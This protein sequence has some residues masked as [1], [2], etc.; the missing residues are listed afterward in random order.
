MR[1]FDTLYRT[2]RVLLWGCLLF[3][4]MVRAGGQNTTVI[5]ADFSKSLI[6]PDLLRDSARIFSVEQMLQ[7]PY[8]SQFRSAGT[9]HLSFGADLSR[10]WMRFS[11]QNNLA[12]P[13]TLILWLNRKNFDEFRLWQ[14]KA[15]G[16]IQAFKEVGANFYDD[17]RFSLT[18][19]YYIAVT[20]QPGEN[21]FWANASN[22]VG[23]M[24]LGLSLHTPDAFALMNRESVL[25]FGIF[26]GVMLISIVFAGQLFFMH[27]DTMYLLYIG[28]VLTILFREAYNHSAIFNIAPV[29]QRHCISFLMVAAYG[30]FYRYFVRLWELNKWVDRITKWYLSIIFCLVAVF[31]GMVTWGSPTMVRYVFLAVMISILLITGVSI[32]VVVQNFRTN[33]RARIVTIAFTPLAFA[34]ILNLLRNIN[35]VPNYPFIQSAVM[36]G[37]IVEVVIFTIAFTRWHR[38]IAND[39]DLLQLKLSVEQQERLLAVQSAEQRVKDSIARDLHDDVAASLS[40]IRIL[41][42][43]AQEQ[44]ASKAPEAAPLLDQISRSAH[45]TLESIS[46]LIWAVKPHPDYLNDM[47]DR[48]REYAVRVLEAK[49]VDYQMNIPR[50]LPVVDLNV[51]SRRNAYLIFKE[52][53]NNALKHSGC[54]RMDFDFQADGS[55][56]TL[57]IVDN[58]KGFDLNARRHSGIG[59]SS[60]EKRAREINGGLEVLSAPGQGTHIT[61]TLP[62]QKN[63]A[64]EHAALVGHSEN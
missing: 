30:L 48:M 64:R 23:S 13:K 60:M 8:A 26:L 20:L 58:G 12:T 45:T 16:E 11:V 56:M 33:I 61:F 5:D 59:L 63:V 7:E 42:K 40:G 38:S 19:G 9:P 18:N 46:D 43:V 32:V 6:T 2:G 1:N 27:R 28:Y 52:A 14:Q 4:P 21:R 10:W 53:V 29:M 54:T 57:H 49:D 51:E 34:F 17:A 44:F 35:V 62:L 25:L 55:K 50:N 41:S 3:L 39:R 47:A 15:S 37:F 31:G 36:W 22:Q 24:H